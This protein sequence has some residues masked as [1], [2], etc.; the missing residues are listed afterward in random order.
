[1]LE[2]CPWESENERRMWQGG[3]CDIDV[4]KGRTLKLPAKQY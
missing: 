3:K 4:E 2:K 1:M